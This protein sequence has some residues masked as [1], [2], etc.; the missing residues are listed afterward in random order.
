MPE[1]IG[2]V[3]QR[4]KIKELQNAVKNLRLSVN[5]LNDRIDA[6]YRITNE[7]K[8]GTRGWKPES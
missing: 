8:G 7:L 1:K 2:K 5:N 4:E 6:L 3:G